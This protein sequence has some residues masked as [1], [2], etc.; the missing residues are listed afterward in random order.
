M[1][2]AGRKGLA[3]CVGKTLDPLYLS[4]LLL[5]PAI[6]MVFSSDFYQCFY[7]PKLILIYGLGTAAV[8]ALMSRTEFLMP[9]RKIVLFLIAYAL[10]AAVGVISITPRYSWMQ[11]LFLYA[12]GMLYLAIINLSE[13]QRQSILRVIYYLGMI[14][15]LIVLL[16]ALQLNSMLPAAPLLVERTRPTGTIGNPEFLATLLGFSFFMGLNQLERVASRERKILIY[17]SLLLM[18]LGIVLTHNKGT[19]LFLGACFLW[20]RYPSAKVMVGLIVILLTVVGLYFPT[21]IRG[22]LFLWITSFQMFKNHFWRGVGLLQFDNFYLQTIRDLFSSS[23][24]LALR[25]GGFTSSVRDAHNIVL[26]HATELGIAG[27]IL[28]LLFIVHVYRL[29]AEN[30]TYLGIA[31]AFLF[32]KSLYTVVLNSPTSMILLI[33]SLGM[34]ANRQELVRWT[35]PAWLAAPAAICLAAFASGIYLGTSDYYYQQGLRRLFMGDKESSYALFTKSITINPENSDS[36]LGLAYAE[37]LSGKSSEMDAY[38]QRAIK[39]RHNMDAYK[40]SAHMYF[41]SGLQSQA[42]PLYEF[43]LSVFP[44]HLTS[45]AKLAVISM[46][47]HNYQNAKMLSVRLLNTI[48]RRKN[49]S[50]LKNMEIARNVLGRIEGGLEQ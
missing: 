46:E 17:F 43:L 11:L 48:S 30:K 39:Y 29:I 9:P 28:S 49:A 5:I 18:L 34:L 44:E 38:I 8:I 36:C 7:L 14:Q 19:L 35:F 10:V 27:L 13:Q 42:K 1:D 15:A 4:N 12:A 25:F 33:I 20:R 3:D 23:S 26:H 22:R 47:N 37:F 6:F 40:I 16:Q 2:Q 50:D 31:L 21:S 41:Y 45:M 24:A 32:Y